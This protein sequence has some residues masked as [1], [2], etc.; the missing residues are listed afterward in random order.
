MSLYY[1]DDPIRDFNRKDRDDQKKL[2]RRPVCCLCEEHIQDEYAY[3][4]GE[5]WYCEDCKDGLAEKLLEAC[6]EQVPDLGED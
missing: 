6:R 1:S 4:D 5:D 3:R 2:E